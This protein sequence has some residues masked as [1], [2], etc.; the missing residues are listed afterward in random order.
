MGGKWSGRILFLHRVG[1][2]LAVAAGLWTDDD[3]C[4]RDSACRGNTE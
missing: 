4:D 1:D 3:P 2:S